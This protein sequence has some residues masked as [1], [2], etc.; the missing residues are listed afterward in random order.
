MQTIWILAVAA[1]DLDDV[2][3]IAVRMQAG[4]EPTR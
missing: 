1:G 4:S 3:Q 2:G